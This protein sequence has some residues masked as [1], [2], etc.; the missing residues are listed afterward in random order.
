MLYHCLC[1]DQLQNCARGIF[2]IGHAVFKYSD[3]FLK[4]SGIGVLNPRVS[5]LRQVEQAAEALFGYR[6]I[7]SRKGYGK[8]ETQNQS[9]DAAHYLSLSYRR[10]RCGNI[11]GRKR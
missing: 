3:G 7:I 1:R 8:I 9:R 6:N 11:A 10:Q 2:L 4:L 5:Y